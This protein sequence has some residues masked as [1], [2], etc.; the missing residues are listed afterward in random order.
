ML[1]RKRVAESKVGNDQLPRALFC[2]D[3]D[4][5]KQQLVLSLDM[6]QLGEVNELLD[7]IHEMEQQ[8]PNYESV[9]DVHGVLHRDDE[10]YQSTNARDQADILSRRQIEHMEKQKMLKSQESRMNKS[11]SQNDQSSSSGSSSSNAI[12]NGN[13]G[14]LKKR[15]IGDGSLGGAKKTQRG[16]IGQ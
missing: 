9:P 12:D 2:Q 5:D 16:L 4:T 10:L 13:V 7:Q 6:Q 3:L 1:Q 14:G 15:S 8:L 11:Q